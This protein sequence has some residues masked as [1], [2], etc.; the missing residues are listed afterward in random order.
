MVILVDKIQRVLSP[1]K[2]CFRIALVVWVLLMMLGSVTHFNGI[3]ETG[4]EDHHHHDHHSNGGR[5]D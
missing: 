3:K 4:K 2:W 1:Y 5:E